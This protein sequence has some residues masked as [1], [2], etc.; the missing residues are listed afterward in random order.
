MNLNVSIVDSQVRGLADKLRIELGEALGRRLDNGRLRSVAFVLLCVKTLLDLSDEEALERLTEGGGDFG[1]DAIHLSDIVEGEF[2]VTFFQCKYK[3][4]RQDGVSAFPED[5][6]TKALQAVMTLFDPQALVSLNPRLQ[7]RVEEIRSLIADGNIP[8]VRVLLCNNGQRWNPPGDQL[9]QNA[10]LGQQVLFEHVNHDAIV[11]IL[12]S[13]KPVDE[14]LEFTGKAV[15]EDFS[16]SRIFVGKMAV[17]EIARVMDTHGDRLLQ[18]NIRRYLGLMGNRVNEGIRATLKSPE[19]RPNFFFYN[20]GITLICTQFTYNALQGE[21]F[22]VKV[23]GLQIINGGQTCKTIQ[24]TLSEI[25]ESLIDSS[26]LEEAFVLVRLYQVSEDTGD[27]VQEI[28]YATNSQNPVDLRDLRSNDPIQKALEISIRDLGFE[29]RRQR[30]DQGTRPSD[31]TA[32]TAAEAVLS[33]WRKCP[34]QAKFRSGEHFGKLYDTIFQPNLN[35]AQAVAAVLLFRIAEN[36][37]KRPSQGAPD[38]TPY[39]SCFAAMLMGR[40]LLK[41]LGIDL[42]S[43]DHR[44]FSTA[45]AL[46]ERKGEKYFERASTD[47][48]KALK[49]LYGRKS[50]TLQ[51]LSATFRRG[52]LLAELPPLLKPNPPLPAAALSRKRT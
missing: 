52:D 2:S 34:Q 47:I 15:V 19:N 46:I 42:D 14:T 32:S 43:L 13:T 10:K 50:I 26:A 31:I 22:K 23:K 35:G 48:T 12:Q 49:R 1:V 7:A 37:R 8:R 20:N 18:R 29:Y 45:K 33:V 21:G 11:Q 44:N 17:S 24:S 3:H 28:T 38:H 5:G 25:R 51:R 39:S 9:I 41:D 16:Y 30:S 40:Y 36:K 4:D 6:V 27:L